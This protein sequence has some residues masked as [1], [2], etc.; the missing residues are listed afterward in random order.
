MKKTY[1]YIVIICLMTL[2]IACLSLLFGS[3]DLTIKDICQIITGSSDSMIKTNVFINLRLP[4]VCMGILAGM[5][6]GLAGSIYQVIFSNPLASPDLTGVASGASLGAA[7][8]IVCRATKPFM[9]TLG[10]FLSGLIALFIMLMLVKMTR[11]MKTSSIVLAGIIVSA[12]ADAILMILKYLADPVGELAAI[13]F[14]T[15]GS[16]A[17]ITLEKFLMSF[18]LSIVPLI[19][20]CFMHRQITMLSF[21]DEQAQYLGL[22]AK[23]FRLFVLILT[24]W[25]VASVISITGVISFVG[26]IAPHIVFLIMKKRTGYFYFLSGVVG[27]LIILIADLFARTVMIYAEL[28]LSILTIFIA[29]PLLMFWMYRHRGEMI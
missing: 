10:A 26:L 18:L 22:N 19:L 11:S 8:A 24:T 15:M 21:G 29:V 28:P 6:L 1:R 14:W 27:A 12:L 5:A 7:I 3:Y 2:F 20:L 16:L 25:L 13:E 23:G 4:R 9:L 17:S